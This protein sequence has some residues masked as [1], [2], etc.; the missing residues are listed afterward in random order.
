MA[1]GLVVG[2]VLPE[3]E[4]HEDSVFRGRLWCDPVQAGLSQS[5]LIVPGLAVFCCASF[6]DR[7]I[8]LFF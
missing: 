7:N 2:A 8:C 6:M 4:Q 5:R 1:K 3:L